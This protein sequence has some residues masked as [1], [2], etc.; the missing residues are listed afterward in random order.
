MYLIVQSIDFVDR[1]ISLEIDRSVTT[2]H[3]DH[4]QKYMNYCSNLGYSNIDL[5][6]PTHMPVMA[7]VMLQQI[8]ST[9]QTDEAR[10]E[11]AVTPPGSTTYCAACE[12]EC[13]KPPNDSGKHIEYRICCTEPNN[14]LEQLTTA[15]LLLG[16]SV[17]LDEASLSYLRLCLYEL[18]ANS[19]E[20]GEFQGKRPVVS[21]SLSFGDTDIDVTYTDNAA[22]FSTAVKKS[23]NV[24]DKIRQR[25]KR[26]LGLFL[27][28]E[29]A[30]ELDYKR[31]RNENSTRFKIE[32]KDGHGYD[33]TRRAEMNTL[34]ID[35]VPTNSDET[36]IVKP[37]GSI[38]STTVPKF[39]AAISQV[40]GSGHKTL[41]IDLSETD[42]I[43]SS[44]VGLL[45]GT[46]ATL[47]EDGGDL[48]LMNIPK[49][50]ND[51]FEILNIKMH[52]RILNDLSDLKVAV[53]S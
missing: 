6:Y 50:I 14:T 43:S 4:L 29:I 40:R 46:V 11:T 36:V 33:L 10:V 35:I 16:A 15:V 38:N 28:Q 8:Q 51:I 7:F 20:H 31:V 17:P 21:V 34:S 37:T 22:P 26:G 25:S 9:V 12:F 53:K 5:F 27:L 49:L 19:L 45:L 47:R 44:G 18:A 2:A 3:F 41:V 39:D 1:S 23:I 52:F 13:V 30:T 24:G 42:F 48:A 32:R